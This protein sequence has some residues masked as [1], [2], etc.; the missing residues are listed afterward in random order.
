MKYT[1]NNI[2][3]IRTNFTV[4]WTQLKSSLENG[5]IGQLKSN[6]LKKTIGKNDRKYRRVK[7]IC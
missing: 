6:K 4:G 7:D 3:S 5:K 2:K 1:I